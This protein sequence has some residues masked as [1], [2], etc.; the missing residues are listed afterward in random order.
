MLPW[1][2]QF[3]VSLSTIFRCSLERAFKSPMLC[4]VSKVHTGFGPMPR[5][6]HC[7]DDAD[8]GRTGAKKRVFAKKSWTFAGGEAS[9]DR[10]IER[11]ENEYWKIEVADF[12][13]WMLGF[14]RFVGEW[15][16]TELAPDEIRVDYTYTLHADAALLAPAQWLFAKAFWPVYMRRVL[17]NVRKL[18]YSNEP[19]QF[20]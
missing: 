7:E 2:M 16:T 3:T 12:K 8:W 14:T 6:T 5:V 13:T 9:S 17:E 11:I 1:P 10:V 18:A 20:A 4:D 15:K 19:Y